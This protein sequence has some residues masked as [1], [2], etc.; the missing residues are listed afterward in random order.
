MSKGRRILLSS[1]LVLGTLFAL[2]WPYLRSV[3][4]PN[5][6]FQE[7]A[8]VYIRSGDQLDDLIQQLV[9]KKLIKRPKDFERVANWMSY[10]PELRPGHYLID[11]DK[12]NRDII[13]PLR[14]GEQD[15]VRFSFNRFRSLDR[16]LQIVE[17]Q[18]HVDTAAIRSCIEDSTC[19]QQY[20]IKDG[21]ELSAFIPNT[22]EFWWYQSAEDFMSRM[23]TE[24][25]RFWAQKDRSE[26]A[27]DLGLD[28]WEVGVLASI[29]QEEQAKYEDE[30]SQIAGLYLNRLDRDMA[31]QADPTIKFALQDFSIR[32]VAFKHIDQAAEAE[33]SAYSTYKHKGLPPGPLA[34]PDPRAL[35]AV[36]WADDHDYIFMCAKADFSGRHAFAE[37]H[38][39]HQR[40]AMAYHRAQDARN[41]RIE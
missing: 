30:W 9:D 10:G 6:V 17:E 7:D 25:K 40:N 41:I 29:V 31:L 27:E 15:P 11:P 36:L 28:S 2:G 8:S 39:Q 12:S 37:D 21:N 19:R 14:I 24:R 18:L 32:R 26:R 16:F 38:W 3:I 33:M 5:S 35:D 23:M 13:V 4:Q 20:G 1:V 34:C 22:Y